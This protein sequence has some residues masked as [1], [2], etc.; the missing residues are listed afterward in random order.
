MRTPLTIDAHYATIP[1]MKKLIIKKTTKDGSEGVDLGVL[2]DGAEDDA[3]MPSEA[4]A[5]RAAVPT[6]PA[7]SAPV[8][9]VI[10]PH[11]FR[12]ASSFDLRPGE[13]GWS[14]LDRITPLLL[15]EMIAIATAPVTII[16]AK[17]KLDALKELI[18]RPMPAR[19]VYDI[20]T[21]HAGSEFDRMTDSQ[22]MDFVTKQIGEMRKEELAEASTPSSPAKDDTPDE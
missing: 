8:P 1:P 19:Q 10:H 13:D 9:E 14:Y 17:V 2:F 5:E 4:P 21:P 11:Q 6:T 15:K 18:Q 22:V 16:S 3:P 7:D 12:V 20:R